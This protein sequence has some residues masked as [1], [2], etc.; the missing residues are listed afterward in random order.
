MEKNA[1]VQAYIV[2]ICVL[3]LPLYLIAARPVKSPN[4]LLLHRE[5]ET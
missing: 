3:R 4:L 2:V 1:I 5:G